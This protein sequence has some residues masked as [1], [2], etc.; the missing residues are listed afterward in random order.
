MVDFDF[1]I[2]NGNFEIENCEIKTPI[3]FKS[4]YYSF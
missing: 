3:K 1:I 2:Q 4:Q